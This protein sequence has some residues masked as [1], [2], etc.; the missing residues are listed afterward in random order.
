MFDFG[1]SEILVAAV[2]GLIV[3]GP[4]KLPR[5]ARTLGLM[6]GKVQRYVGDLKE[7]INR[8]AE[9]DEFN[10]IR[11]SVEESAAEIEE[12]V[13]SS[14]SYVDK[15]VRAVGDT[16]NR[17]SELRDDSKKSGADK[18]ENN[19]SHSSKPRETGVLAS[20]VRDTEAS[21]NRSTDNAESNN[22]NKIPQAKSEK[23]KSATND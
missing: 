17:E 3:I 7:D 19:V 2:I 14:V 11:S 1:F 16:F 22:L 15:E 6:F 18:Q 13:V 5:V 4:E 10:E 20:A 8:Q 21:S 12:S 9:I 23:N